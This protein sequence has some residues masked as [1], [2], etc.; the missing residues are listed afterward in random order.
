VAQSFYQYFVNLWFSPFKVHAVQA[1]YVAAIF[2]LLVYL[3]NQR[4]R[5]ALSGASRRDVGR[6]PS[7]RIRR[8]RVVEGLPLLLNRAILYTLAILMI[9]R[10]MGLPTSAEVLPILLGLL[11]V[12]LVAFRDALRDAVRGYYI[13]YDHIYAPGD[14][15]SIGE[16]TGV[17]ID[18][19]L[20]VTRLQVDRGEGREMIISN[21]HVGNV[22]NLSRVAASKNDDGSGQ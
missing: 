9:V 2:E 4:L 8:R 14:R 19:S 3:T 10:V 22:V 6:E 13:M 12:V 16:V 21:R 5:R 11:L 18:L 20:R 1:I 7:E 15:I 17:V